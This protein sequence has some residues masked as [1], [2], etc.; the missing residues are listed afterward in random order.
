MTPPFVQTSLFESDPTKPSPADAL[1]AAE[2]RFKAFVE[3]HP[4]IAWIKDSEGRYIYCNQAL[5][6]TYK[7]TR[8]QLLGKTDEC[9]VPAS[10]AAK[11]KRLHSRILKQQT[12]LESV[13]S[14][15][16]PD[17]QIRHWKIRRFPFKAQN[18]E[19]CIGGI[20]T[21]VTERI[22]AEE[23]VRL[24]EERYHSL[25][26]NAQ[27]AIF[28]LAPDGTLLSA[29]SAFERIT[30]WSLD[31]CVD[32]PFAQWII[33]SEQNRFEEAVHE[34]MEGKSPPTLEVYLRAAQT[35][36]VPLEI[37]L[38]AQ[39]QKGAVASIFGIGRDIRKRR[40]L[41]NQLRQVQKLESIGQLAAG[42]AHDF[43]NIL[44]VIQGHTSLVSLNEELPATTRESI[45]AIKQATDRA[46][47]LTRQLLM[48]S[49]KQVMQVE[50]LDINKAIDDISRMLARLL[51]EDIHL[52]T[53]CENSTPLIQ[54]DVGML[55]QVILNLAVNAR[56]AMPQG[57]KLTLSTSVVSFGPQTNPT[58]AEALNGRFVCLSV[59]DTGCGIPAEDIPHVFEPFFTTKEKESGTGL[60]LATVYGIVKQHN[61][62]VDVESK[63]EQGT[64]FRIYLPAEACQNDKPFRLSQLEKAPMGDET[65]LL[66]E[67]EPSVGKLVDTLLRKFGYRTL[68]AADGV[69]ALK[70]WRRHRDEV[71][72]LLTDLIM[73]RGISGGELAEQLVADR[74]SLRVVFTSGYSGETH[75]KNLHLKEGQNFISKPYMPQDLA[76]II[77]KQL[78]S[79]LSF[80]TGLKRI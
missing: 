80:G 35:E 7:K 65:I 68:I 42:I 24:S 73:P 53:H 26:E 70:L 77:R 31:R 14:I 62:H 23:A 37:T 64:V 10:I 58:I 57:G 28:S 15:P 40:H 59:R 29:N 11:H 47:N 9:I 72:L 49:R 30:G 44:S 2:S 45:D 48:F 33:P 41:E 27:D 13:E 36:P 79:P 22:E 18:G 74:P 55:E 51:P 19:D 4:S 56:D 39:Q 16:L 20:A 50:P 67:D 21:D 1:K 17:G 3:E 78:D 8:K 43:N 34:L 46:S 6:N 38:T 69:E 32:Q 54:G 66:V 60:G 5:L 63:V 25:M 71:D 12:S 75:R 52:Q 76:K 61:G